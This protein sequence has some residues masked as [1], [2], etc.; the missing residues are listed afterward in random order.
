MQLSAAMK[1]VVLSNTPIELE[2]IQAFKLQ[3]KGLVRVKDPLISPSCQLYRKYFQQAL[4][5]T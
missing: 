4:S 3:S 2:P 1:R 5:T